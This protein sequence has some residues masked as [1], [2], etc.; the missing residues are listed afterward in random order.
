MKIQ[1]TCGN[2]LT[3]VMSNLEVL[4]LEPCE[5]CTAD[6]LAVMQERMDKWLDATLGSKKKGKE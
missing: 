1:C 4:E 3:V 2:L 5:K 6:V